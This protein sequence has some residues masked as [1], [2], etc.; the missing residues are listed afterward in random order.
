MELKQKEAIML[1]LQKKDVFV[2]SSVWWCHAY[3]SMC[4]SLLEGLKSYK[5]L[6]YVQPDLSSSGSTRLNSIQWFK[7]LP[8]RQ[9]IMKYFF[10]SYTAFPNIFPVNS[11]R[12]TWLSWTI[13]N[14][15]GYRQPSLLVY[16]MYETSVIIE[17][18]ERSRGRSLHLLE[19]EREN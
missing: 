5:S 10:T 17:I 8:L 2:V 16:G 9:F 3:T 4:M 18:E 1:F 7:L 14:G 12:L 15:D 19:R 6:Y 13:L 11:R